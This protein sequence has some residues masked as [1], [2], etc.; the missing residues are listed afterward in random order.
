[1][2]LEHFHLHLQTHLIPC[3]TV[4]YLFCWQQTLRHLT[5]DHFQLSV[6]EP[7]TKAPGKRHFDLMPVKYRLSLYWKTQ[8]VWNKSFRLPRLHRSKLLYGFIYIWLFLLDFLIVTRFTYSVPR[9]TFQSKSLKPS[10]SSLKNN[11]SKILSKLH[12]AEMGFFIA[13]S[14]EK[15][16]NKD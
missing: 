1:M 4:Y 3:G 16:S 5:L 6:L 15:M 11:I 9:S 10:V 8:V 7:K 14:I 12:L 13:I 2:T